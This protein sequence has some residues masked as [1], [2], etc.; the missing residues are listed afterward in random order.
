M[1][2]ADFVDEILVVC[3]Q[4]RACASVRPAPGG[5]KELLSPRRLACLHCGL[6]KDI[7]PNAAT[8]WGDD[9]CLDCYFG[10]PLWLVAGQGERIL[11]AYN[12]AHLAYIESFV[13][14]AHRMR[15]LDEPGCLNRS[16]ISRLPRWIKKAGNRKH[17]L[18]LIQELK[19]S[20]A[21]KRSCERKPL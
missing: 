16:V 1:T 14:A 12:F 21:G 15:R 9:A 4:C 6:A 19:E 3:P 20:S 17:V 8:F 5:E 18:T 2:I 13:A 11:W 10:L 7:E